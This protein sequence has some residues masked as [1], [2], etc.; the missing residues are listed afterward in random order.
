M[1]RGLEER[2]PKA[3]ALAEGQDASSDEITHLQQGWPGIPGPPVG[4]FLISLGYVSSS[5][6]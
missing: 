3:L 4:H 6:P 1:S 5:V 2:E